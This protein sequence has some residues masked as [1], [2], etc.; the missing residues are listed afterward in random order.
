MNIEN[1]IFNEITRKKFNRDIVYKKKSIIDTIKKY[2]SEDKAIKLIW[3]WWV[4]AKKE[5]NIYD[6]KSCENLYNLNK[7]IK[8]VYPKWLDMSFIFS[9]K[10]WE[11]NWYKRENIDLYVDSIKQIFNKLN[12]KYIN[13]DDL[14]QKYEIS[15]EKINNIYLNK[16][17][18]WWNNIENTDKIELNAD[19]INK[20]YSKKEAAKKYFIMRD[21][22][23]NILEKE[24]KN[25]IF[26]TFSDSSM[27]WVLPDMAT[28]YLYGIKKWSSQAPWFI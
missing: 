5:A 21:L 2:T 27:R 1:I 24:F 6:I 10:H 19:K 12:F 11:F 28:I 17:D 7:N 22:E 18:K 15:I 9:T 26:N 14:W 4:W 16:E 23:K 13:L 8:R 20:V 25:Y 3:F